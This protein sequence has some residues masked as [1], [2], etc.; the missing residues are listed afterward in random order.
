M[1]LRHSLVV[2]GLVSALGLVT[3]SGAVAGTDDT[4][5]ILTGGLLSGG[6]MTVGNF[7]GTTLD[8]TAKTTSAA[9]SGF[10]VIDARG[11]GA[12]WNV[13]I[14]ATQFCK[15]DA[16]GLACDL[17]TPRNL[18]ASSLS[19]PQLSVAK[20]DVSASGLPSI[21]AGAYI[22][23]A[24]S[25]VKVASAAADGSGMGTYDFTQGGNWTLSLPAS[26]YAGTYRST[27]TV[28]VNSGP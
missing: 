17:V 21:T 14:G 6:N 8:G 11:T 24:G 23:D 20:G 18:P 9:G 22:L 27:V 5:V 13:T 28:S 26:T 16:L 7:G 3:V 10:N 19:M 12:G 4:E 1:P 15:L 2:F 25:S